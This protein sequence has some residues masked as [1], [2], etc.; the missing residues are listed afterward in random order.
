MT[1][2]KQGTYVKE[3]Y[4]DQY[5]KYIQ[6]KKPKEPSIFKKDGKQGLLIYIDEEFLQEKNPKPTKSDEQD[7]EDKPKYIELNINKRIN[8]YFGRDLGTYNIIHNE[9]YLFYKV[10][11]KDKISRLRERIVDK[12][13]ENLSYFNFI[14]Q[15]QGSRIKILHS[16]I[17]LIKST[18]SNIK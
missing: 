11:E 9:K 3:E 18:L 17:E 12:L 6:N 14:P 4:L 2:S 1:G 5:I 13:R 7:D 10:D 8:Y 15:T 16:E